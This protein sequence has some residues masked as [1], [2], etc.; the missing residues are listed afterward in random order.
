MTRADLVPPATP[1]DIQ[2]L[3]F[4]LA[5]QFVSHA[6]E[7]CFHYRKEELTSELFSSARTK[8]E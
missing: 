5:D 1:T 2:E 7:V 6:F 3:S 8:A 4:W